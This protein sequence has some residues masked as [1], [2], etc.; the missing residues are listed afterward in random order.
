MSVTD[1]AKASIGWRGR[2]KQNRE[3]INFSVSSKMHV[4]LV[5]W[6]LS[7]KKKNRKKEI[8]RFHLPRRMEGTK[9]EN[10]ILILS[11]ARVERHAMPG[12]L[13]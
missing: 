5:K 8:Y 6:R 10:Q 1:P 2:L 3:T 11:Y 4:I 9:A 7:A 13:Y 12:R